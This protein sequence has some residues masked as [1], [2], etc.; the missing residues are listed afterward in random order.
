VRYI[1]QDK[2]NSATDSGLRIFEHYFPNVDLKSSKTFFKERED[3]KSASAHISWHDGLWRITDFGNPAVN[4][5]TGIAYVMYR[6]KLTFYDALLFIEEIILNQRTEASSFKPIKWAPEYSWREMTPADQKGKYY[7]TFKE[8]PSSEDL[9][10]IGRYVDEEVLAHFNCRVVDKYEFCGTS[11]KEN[12]DIVH[13]FQST[14]DFPIFLFDY[15]DFQKL[16]KPHETDKKYRFQYVGNKPKDFIYGLQQIIDAKN[17]FADEELEQLNLPREK[18]EARVRDI[19]RCSGESDAMNLYSIGFHPYWLNSESKDFTWQMYKEVNDLCENHYQIMDLD[20]TGQREAMKNALKHIDQYTIELPSWL[21][22]K[23]D[24]R[25]NPC[26]DLKDFINLA[27][28]GK[29]STQYEF[30]VLKNAALRVKFWSK[31]VDEKEKKKETY[32]INLEDFYFFLKA[33]GFYQMET[34][35]YKNATYCYVKITGKAVELIHPADIKRIIKRFTKEWIRSKKLMD[36]KAILNKLNASNQISEAN[37]DTIEEI[38]LNFK[39]YDRFTEYLHFNNISVRIQKNKIETV[40]QVDLPNYILKNLV[41]N[42]KKVSH[43]IDKDFRLI[44]EQP[45]EINANSE[46]QEL[47]DKIANAAT[48]EE[49]IALQHEEAQ[50]ADIDKYEVKINS[51][52]FFTNFLWDLSRLHWKKELEWK[53]LSAED[54]K[55]RKQPLTE[56][57]IKEQNLAFANLC[58]VIGYHCA[59]YK[60]PAK[61]W[62]TLLQDNKVS[63][64]GNASGGSGKS[65]LS[66]AIRYVRASFYKG[67]RSLSDKDVFKF[68]YDGL[69]EFH[70]FIE[71]DDLWEYADFGFFYTQIT[72]PREV[73]PKNYSSIVLPYEDSGKMLIST[74]YELMSVDSSTYRRILNASVSDYYHEKTKLNDYAETRSPLTKYERRLYDDFT[75]E[76]W[77]KFYNFIAYCIQLQMRFHKIQ[78]PMANLEKR[79]ARRAMSAGL[80]KDEDFFK[81]A[82]GYFI[83]WSGE[84]KKPETSPEDHGYWNTFIVKDHAFQ[85]FCKGLSKKQQNDYRASK[86]KNQVSAWCDYYGYKLNPDPLCTGPEDCRRII[87]K[88]EGT[89]AECFYIDASPGA[90]KTEVSTKQIEVV[91][92]QPVDDD[93]EPF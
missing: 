42:N 80:G 64:V 49:R 19:F 51:D 54:K 24:W 70:D 86:F 47:L 46:Y 5:L 10:S 84:G 2:I 75:D 7:F 55:I 61:A 23:R 79:Q 35:Y 18:P 25:N 3:E 93:D 78:P 37:M 87:R 73:N 45:V 36:A 43:L 28:D 17:E 57:E 4:G 58:F 32:N 20:A 30:L 83:P 40:K 52:F 74:N 29:K 60:D 63:E 48:E 56:D 91:T 72:G 92:I 69:T 12:R 31:T 22:S 33:N 38:E 39:N 90:N 71:I 82:N 50:F 1:D 88:V 11:K 16:Y 9:A 68:F 62:L 6:E 41:V 26:K 15:G 89:T 77:I 65:L 85:N 27:G 21:K 59:Q 66:A 81:W 67:G 76:E 34:G 8:K 14:K 44:K 53:K 13:I